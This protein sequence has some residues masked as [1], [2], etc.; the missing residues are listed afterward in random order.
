MTNDPKHNQLPEP[1]FAL[2]L[3]II[4]GTIDPLLEDSA[5]IRGDAS[6]AWKRIKDDAR[7][8]KD[9]ARAYRKLAG[10][11]PEASSKFLRDLVGLCNEGGLGIRPDLVDLA[12]GNT[13]GLTFKFAD[14]PAPDDE[15]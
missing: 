7:V 12:E 2:A 14:V 6:A 3:K 11:S 8:D 13:E 10:Q 9:A 1:D 5:E 15:E 4:T